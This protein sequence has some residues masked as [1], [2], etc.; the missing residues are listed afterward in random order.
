MPSAPTPAAGRSRLQLQ[1]QR[2]R[3]RQRA[4]V[5]AAA[6]LATG[7][8]GAVTLRTAPPVSATPRSQAAPPALARPL[9][10]PL[11]P[12]QAQAQ[13]QGG[14]LAAYLRFTGTGTV[15]AKPDTATLHFSTVGS[16]SSLAA[17]QNQASARMTTLLAAFQHAGIAQADLATGSGWAGQDG[18]H[19]GRYTASQELT[20]TVRDLSAPGRCWRSAATTAPAPATA[21]T[22]RWRT[23]RRSTPPRCTPRSTTPAPRPTPP[24]A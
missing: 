22:S 11:A 20:V 9:A 18:E 5:A 8:A 14:Q 16:G 2:G 1:C 10:A 21:R 19:P 17:A 4:I 24:P 23:P 13:A 3:T 15:Q 6:L 7:I 12:P